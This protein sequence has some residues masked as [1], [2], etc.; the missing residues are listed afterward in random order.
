M[1]RARQAA[2]QQAAGQ[3]APGQQAPGQ[4]AGRS[5]RR[6]AAWAVVA[7]AAF[8][9]PPVAVGLV[10]TPAPA[11]VRSVPPLI[12]VSPGVA[13]PPGSTVVARVVLGAR[14]D[15]TIRYQVAGLPIGTT[16]RLTRVSRT[17]RSLQITIP[18]GA[19]PGAYRAQFV[20]LNRGL[21][22]VA[23]F[24]IVVAPPPVARR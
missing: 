24:T 8:G 7:V 9:A 12:V 1:R 10:A 3:Q 6:R 15:A 19:P 23:D 5:W 22:R 14:Y 20:T 16:A 17:E 13:V 21:R 4:Q 2:G 11:A 18:F